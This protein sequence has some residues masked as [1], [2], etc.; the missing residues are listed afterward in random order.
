MCV[1]KSHGAQESREHGHC[2]REQLLPSSAI[3]LPL[4]EGKSIPEVTQHW[5]E[6]AKKSS[7]ASVSVDGCLMPLLQIKNSR[8][9]R[10]STKGNLASSSSTW[11]SSSCGLYTTIATAVAVE[12]L[13]HF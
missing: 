12:F 1:T 4:A 13:P 9:T 11:S 2:I 6:Q 5:A 8:S 3:Q 7:T 10:E